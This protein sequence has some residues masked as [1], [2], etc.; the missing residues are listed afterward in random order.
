VAQRPDS[1]RLVGS[2]ACLAGGGT[3]CGHGDA[4]C[5]QLVCGQSF[6]N[7]VSSAEETELH[8]LELCDLEADLLQA[9][10][11]PCM[12]LVMAWMMLKRAIAERKDRRP[13]L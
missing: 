13:S 6:T 10:P 1:R 3:G 9:D 7:D 4:P 5:A 12:H 2:P 11:H 8:G